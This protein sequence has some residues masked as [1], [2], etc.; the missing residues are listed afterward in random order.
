MWGSSASHHVNLSRH[1][2][3]FPF[4]SSSDKKYAAKA[5]N[6]K[7]NGQT[8]PNDLLDFLMFRFLNHSIYM[9]L[10]RNLHTGDC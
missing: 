10:A 4:D 1:H 6:L 7:T 3:A 2:V 8:V 9:R 5:A